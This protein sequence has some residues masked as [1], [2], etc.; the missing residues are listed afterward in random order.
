MD[1]QNK[2]GSKP[3]KQNN[4]KPRPPGQ[5]Q[6]RSARRRRAAAN[7]RQSVGTQ[8]VLSFQGPQNPILRATD[9]GMRRLTMR[10]RNGISDQGVAFLKCAFAPPDFSGSSLNGVPD[11]FRGLSLTRKHRSV[12]PMYFDGG[13][14]VYILLCPVPGVAFFSA[15]VAPGT[16]VLASTVFTGVPYSDYASMFGTDSFS[17]ADQVTNFR[18]I[19]N[20]FEIVPTVNQMTWSGNI[21]IWKLPLSVI[22][23]ESASSANLRSVTGLD[24]CNS[25]MANCYTGPFIMGAYTAAY[26]RNPVFN[27]E[28]IMESVDNARIPNVIGTPDFGQLSCQSIGGFTGFDNGFESVLIKISGVTG[29]QTAL[30]KTWACIEYQPSPKSVLYSFT[31]LSPSDK[32]AMELY[33]EIILGLP[34]AVPFEQ[35]ENFWQRVLRIINQITNVGA[36][37]PGPIGLASRGVNLLGQAASAWSGY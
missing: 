2:K 28:P 24:G 13:G 34:I 12:A 10:S 31:S 19:S 37:V 7:I 5:G 3:S 27:F 15:I 20:H 21:Q 36:M 32:L 6:S 33:R 1:K 30:V 18:F 4:Q 29:P 35:N 14:D 25:A 16:P 17:T 23:R 26:G 11:E 8:K 9:T 22:M